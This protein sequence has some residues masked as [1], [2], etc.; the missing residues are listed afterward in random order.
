MRLLIYLM[1]ATLFQTF[2]MILNLLSEKPETFT[3]DENFPILIYPNKIKNRIVFKIKPRYKLEL[4]TNKTM[5]LLG[6]GPIIDRDKNGDNLPELKK[7]HS[8]L[9]HCNVLHNDYLQNSK[10]LY[11][12]VSDKSFG[13]FLAIEPKTL[14]QSKATDS[15]FD[16]IEIWI[17]DQNNKKQY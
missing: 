11:T 12:F 17:T 9:I 6:E 1:V 8:V 4:L 14:I 13:Q 7:T 2:K 3:A 16:Y 15:T 10:L 5:Y